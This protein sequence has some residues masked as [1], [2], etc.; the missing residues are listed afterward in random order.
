MLEKLLSEQRVAFDNEMSA[1]REAL[2][3]KARR[4]RGRGRL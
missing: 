3:G 2:K 1:M 4:R